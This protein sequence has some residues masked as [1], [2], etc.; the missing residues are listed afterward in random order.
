MDANN[1]TVKQAHLIHTK[2]QMQTH[3]SKEAFT[4]LFVALSLLC[5]VQRALSIVSKHCIHL[6]FPSSYSFF[7]LYL[8]L[9]P[10][11][12]LSQVGVDSAFIY[13]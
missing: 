6:S 8:T 10:S 5:E 11:F 1:K 12:S 2:M 7:S 4:H 3:S 13:Y 9:S